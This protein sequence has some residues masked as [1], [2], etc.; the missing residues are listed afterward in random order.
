MAG[1]KVLH[2]FSPT[3]IRWIELGG[4]IGAVEYVLLKGGDSSFATDTRDR[5]HLAD[6][7]K[8]RVALVL[9]FG[10]FV[11]NFKLLHMVERIITDLELE[12][13][14]AEGEAR[15]VATVEGVGIC[16][17]CPIADHVLHSEIWTP[18][19]HRVRHREIV[20][21]TCERI[22]QRRANARARG[23]PVPQGQHLVAHC[24]HLCTCR[25]AVITFKVRKPRGVGR[26]VKDV[27]GGLV[28]RL[29]KILLAR[30]WAGVAVG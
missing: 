6:Y 26:D 19:A 29:V 7:G 11:K 5:Q 22:Y 30:G 18:L 24:R 8:I 2:E 25:H 20:R 12:P 28:L 21:T 4:R 15:A 23:D 9:R 13:L 1:K 16:R 14:R 3:L 17:R 27:A 10:R